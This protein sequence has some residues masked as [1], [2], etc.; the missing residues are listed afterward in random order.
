MTGHHLGASALDPRG[1]PERAISTVLS[2]G[3]VV[4][5]GASDD[6]PGSM[7]AAPVHNLLAHGYPGRIHVV[8]PNRTQVGGIKAYPTV[9]DL[10]EVPDTAIVVVGADRVP[11]VL[12]ELGELGVASATVVAAGFG[13]AAAGPGG[14]SRSAALAAAIQ[15]TGIRVLGPNTTGVINTLDSYVPRASRNHPATLR[16]GSFA[17]VGQSG[18][19]GNGVFN[20]ALRYGVGV[21]YVVATGNQLDL[22]IWDV[23]THILADER[24][25]SIALLIESLTEAGKVRAV[26]RL[27]RER[28]KA[29]IALHLGVSERGMAIVATHSGSLAGA[30]DVASAVFEEEGIIQVREL[31]QLWEVG[32]LFAAWSGPTGRTDRIAVIS[33][34]GGDAALAADTAERTRLELPPPA[35]GTAKHIRAGFSFA[36]P[37]NPFDLTAEFMGRPGQIELATRTMLADP[38]YDALLFSSLVTVGHYAESM[39]AEV[40]AALADEGRHRV[41]VALRSGLETAPTGLD[42]LRALGV[43]VFEGVERGLHAIAHY[44]A[45]AARPAREVA[46]VPST[47][48]GAPAIAPVGSYWS[49]RMTIARLEVPFNDARLVHTAED[50]VHA[51]AVIG[52]PVVLKSSLPGSGHKLAV[53]GVRLLLATDD[54]IR[55]AA[56]ELLGSAA[57]APDP[58]AGVGLVV[59]RQVAGVAELLVGFHRDPT[60]G[61]IAVIGLG[62]TWTEVYRDTAT[63]RWPATPD[64]IADRLHAT[65]IGAALRG[66]VDI[67]PTFV[68]LLQRVGDWFAATDAVTSVDLNPV[69]VS[70]DG[71]LT[72][73][74][75]RIERRPVPA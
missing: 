65:R 71:R 32:Q 7:P 72:A 43:P 53:G 64:T 54:D 2:P 62:G 59:E 73:V 55:A 4:V 69:L 14:T 28:R 45:H 5:V 8:N 52:H 66:R 48:V 61:S 29:L 36:E 30:A 44:A 47:P 18:A 9:R 41:A 12:R 21:G 60:F 70:A 68:G 17:I 74:D 25:T 15:D 20:R 63:M 6:K 46:P 3:S 42:E 13:E 67:V 23:T 51:A 10:P 56:V 11:A 19:L 31:D 22:D 35:A 34:S 57:V 27:A 37:S 39:Y 33:T 16:P 24:V 26:A 49:D 50:A 38:N 1:R 75:A 40:A 58:R